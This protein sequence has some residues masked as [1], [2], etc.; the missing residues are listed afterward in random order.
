MTALDASPKT[1]S[2][3]PCGV[4]NARVRLVATDL[5]GTLLRSDK[6]V[7]ARTVR[8]LRSVQAAGMGVVI[9]SAR[10]PYGVQ[11]YADLAGVSGLAIC[12]NGA[13]VYDLDRRSIVRHSTLDVDVLAE[14][15][16]ML[17][18]TL[19]DVFFAFVRGLS[20]ACER[21]YHRAARVIDHGEASLQAALVADALELCSEPATKLIVQHP[22]LAPE[23]VLDHLGLLQVAGF[24]ASYS[25]GPFVEVVT[26]GVTKALALD[27]LCSAD[28]I[29]ARD[30]VAFGDA[31]NDLAML[32]WAGLGVAV[33]NAHPSVLAMADEVAASND[34]D[35]VARTLE[36]LLAG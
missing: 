7:S 30:V 26:A 27:G 1:R 29:A 32:A 23:R 24:E 22:T 8:A 36:R 13:I 9:A 31:P 33:A 21:Q 6:T 16:G 20:F 19:P 14:L 15:V 35:G 17:R 3:S 11:H 10:Q 25:G 28:G 18:S 4:H 12:C 34:D 2:R 5:D